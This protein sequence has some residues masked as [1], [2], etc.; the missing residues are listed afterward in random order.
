MKIA[1]YALTLEY[2]EAAFYKAAVAS[3]VVT[4]P[5][6][7]TFA[8]TV[9]CTRPRTSRRSSRPSARPP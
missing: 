8:K 2:L 3:G 6:A 1:N 9:A 7:V 4:D 5:D